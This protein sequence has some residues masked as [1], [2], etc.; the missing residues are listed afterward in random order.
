[1]EEVEAIDVTTGVITDSCK[2][3]KNTSPTVLEPVN[4]IHGNDTKMKHVELQQVGSSVMSQHNGP[5]SL[6]WLPIKTLDGG[7]N[8]TTSKIFIGAAHGNFVQS[9]SAAPF[10]PKQHTKKKI[11]NT[12]KHSAGFLKKIARM[13][14]GDRK[15]IMRI[16]KHRYRKRKARK[17]SLATKSVDIS[18]SQSSKHSNSSVNKDW[19]NWVVMHEKLEV[20]KADVKKIGRAIGVSF[21]GDP[22]NSFNLLTKEGRREW[23]VTGG[24]EMEE[25]GVGGE[26]DD[27]ER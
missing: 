6:D 8:A 16:L 4:F 25:E 20:V 15:E 17:S 10:R 18:T 13:P 27:G 2:K 19:E 11:S 1:M 21:K 5:W 26:R 7:D 9:E 24:S 23:R 3:L 14:S 22:N 12:F